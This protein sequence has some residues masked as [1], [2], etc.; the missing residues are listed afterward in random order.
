MIKG[1]L[2]YRRTMLC[3]ALIACVIF[4]L[5]MTIMGM[6]AGIVMYSILIYLF[7]IG[8]FVGVDWFRYAQKVE[9]LGV[10]SRNLTYS[11]HEYPRQENNIEHLY[12][13]IIASL[14]RLM[15]EYNR[16]KSNPRRWIELSSDENAIHGRGN[17]LKR[18]KQCFLCIY[19]QYVS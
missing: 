11:S 15:E 9:R 3:A 10:I 1:Y 8:V 4:P 6:E 16:W 5:V 19:C 12:S 7:I 17:V 18:R 14:Y 2:R 13:D